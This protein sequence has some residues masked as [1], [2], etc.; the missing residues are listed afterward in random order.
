MT[1]SSAR[2]N[3]VEG[4]HLDVS[5]LSSVQDTR[6][7]LESRARWVKHLAAGCRL[8]WHHL[9]RLDETYLTP[10]STEKP[11]ALMLAL[12]RRLPADELRP[13]HRL[14]V[15]EARTARL[16]FARLVLEEARELALRDPH[17][18]EHELRQVQKLLTAAG[19]DQIDAPRA[20]DL[21][22]LGW[23]YLADAQRIVGHHLEAETSFAAAYL[24]LAA[25]SG[26]REVEATLDELQSQLLR[27]QGQVCVALERLTK[28]ASLLDA[29]G[30]EGRRAEVLGRRGA[31][32]LRLGDEP[33]AL[34]A[35]Q[36][37][38]ALLP[39]GQSL[40]LR[41][42][43]LH[44]CAAIEA[45]L[46]HTEAASVHLEKAA[47][48]YAHHGHDLLRVQRHWVRGLVE[49]RRQRFEA[50]DELLRAAIHQF[51]DLGL[52]RSAVLVLFDLAQ[53]YL[54]AGW[55][56][57]FHELE[58]LFDQLY[59]EPTF[60]AVL[61]AHGG[62]LLILARR[63]GAEVPYLEELVKTLAG[64]ADPVAS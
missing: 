58:K 56:P 11:D 45:R 12:C 40:G 64:E 26:W 61:R 5:A 34:E 57:R 35:T 46:G 54:A 27:L 37:A 17:R 28:A 59:E 13:A 6:L 20:H 15:L 47:P 43:L 18:A 62:E 3:E 22:T 29:P 24:A 30:L 39:E 33:R 9:E 38:L 60:R 19:L 23:A 31:L 25:G 10:I 7:D 50:A 49:L 51:L 44:N 53:L 52:A 48:L 36:T 55:E 41:L 4:E 8:C 1:V 63:K 14:A 2:G 32:L 21:E 42:Y 16:G